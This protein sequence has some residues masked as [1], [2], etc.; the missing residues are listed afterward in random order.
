MNGAPEEPTTGTAPAQNVDTIDA[1]PQAK[2]ES[3]QAFTLVVRANFVDI[4]FTVKN[5]K[6]V[7]VP[8]LDSRDIRVYENGLMQHI[9]N[10]TVDPFPLSVAVIVDQSMSQDY[11]DRVNDS[12]GSLQSAFAPYDEVAVFTYNNGPK[13]VTDFTA[14]QSARL[15][16]AIT[17]SKGTG[18]EPLMAGS[19]SGPLSQTTNINDQN[20]DPNT[21]PNRGHSSTMIRSVRSARCIR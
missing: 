11:M 18:R 13:M 7:L 2:T 9:T 19:L 5:S 10:F 1:Q 12:L 8:G 14:S 20:F 16:Q 3:R 4:P 15:T 17:R 21:S 6:G